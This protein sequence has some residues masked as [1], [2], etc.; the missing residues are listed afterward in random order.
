MHDCEATQARLMDLLFDE[1]GRG[2]R[3]AL[4][5]ELEAC[6]DC[7]G[8]HRALAD[9]LSAL[10]TAAAEL[11]PGEDFWTGY[12]E[13]LRERMAQEI[14]PNIWQQGAGVFGPARAEYRLTF[15]EDEGLPRR[16]ARE[17]RA[18]ADESRLTWPEFKRDPFGFARRSAAAYSLLAYGFFARRDIAL[19][20][21][22]AVLCVS[23]LVGAIFAVENRC[24]VLGLFQSPCEAA[25]RNPHAGLELVGM[26]PAT[27]IPREQP[28]PEE[29][30]AGMNEGKGGGSKPQ[31]ERPQGGGGGGRREQLAASHGKLPTAQLAPQLLTPNPH[32]PALKNPSLPTPVTIDVDPALIK[33]DL[34][35]VPYGLPNS[36]AT[37]ASSGPGTGGGIGT[38]S[39]GGVGEGDGG[40]VGPGRDGN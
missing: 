21:S 26:V 19:A 5:A 40:G 37:L 11:L 39:R 20:T 7:A 31:Y 36:E 8:Q 30:P 16:L 33:P 22:T 10:D 38:G 32:P 28:R 27:D 18:A 17:L 24:S 25:A 9:T 23:I 34:R 13:R 15:L 14:R 35:D 2:Q 4:L 12:G 3:A 6:A 29:G 1:L